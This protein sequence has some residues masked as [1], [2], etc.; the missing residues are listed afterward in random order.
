MNPPTITEKN[1]P[2]VKKRIG[3]L[4][5]R[6]K[7]SRYFQL[8]RLSWA[9]T[10]KNFKEYLKVLQRFYSNRTF[11]KADSALLLS[12]LWTNPFAISKEFLASQ[13]AED[14]YLYGET[15]LTT[16]AEI[17]AKAGIA[18]HDVYLELGSGRGRTCFW[19][20]IF[21]GCSVKGIELIPAFVGKAEKIVKRCNLPNIEFTQEDFLKANLSGASVIYLYGSSLPDEEIAILAQKCATLP[22]GTKIITVSYSLNEYLPS[23]SFEIMH[24]FP[25]EYTWG[26]ADVYV[27]YVR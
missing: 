9:V 15:P 22:A 1:R 14:V 7:I 24:C 21:L 6:E 25:A 17:A 12:Y 26:S 3:N 23:N 8:Y 11:A 27:Q 10:L 16:F 20:N 5:M 19:A 2:L 18:K 4:S 13:G